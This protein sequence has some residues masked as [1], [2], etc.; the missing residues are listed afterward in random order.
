M[1]TISRVVRT[2]IL[3]SVAYSVLCCKA[4]AQNPESFWVVGSD[5]RLR[6][7]PSVE[8]QVLA[9]LQ[10]GDNV[11]VLE[12][13][14][15]RLTIG[16][17]TGSWAKVKLQTM[18]YKDQ[19]GY[20]FDAFLVPDA[21]GPPGL[22]KQAQDL[23]DSAPREAIKVYKR[24][25]REFPHESQI[26]LYPRSAWIPI[27][28]ATL[29]CWQTKGKKGAATPDEVLTQLR[30]PTENRDRAELELLASC[31]FLQWDSPCAGDPIP[32]PAS[33]NDF[34]QY[35]SLSKAF[36][37]STL[38]NYCVNSKGSGLK[39]CFTHEQH[40]GR[41]FWSGGCIEQGK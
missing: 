14:P 10:G 32:G 36:D 37:W 1:N 3:V 26:G 25:L 2:L 18:D 39:Y 9:V 28:I 20:V 11:L 12:H 21:E 27:R 23:S 33:A 15:D 7:A 8:S 30:A 35:L 22:E 17:R 31:T 4:Q 24:I 13:L 34:E 38:K 19:V 6:A 5:I 40:S 41:F 29:E 16:G